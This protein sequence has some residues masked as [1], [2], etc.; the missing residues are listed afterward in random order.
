[1]LYINSPGGD[2]YSGLAVYDTIQA[3]K[4]P[5]HTFVMGLAAS[6]SY[7]LAISGEK[8]H[9]YALK[10]SRLMM[11]QPWQGGGGGQ[12]TDVM[13]QNVEIQGLKSDMIKIIS[14]H[15][16]QTED[17]VKL[18]AERDFWMNGE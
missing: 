15:T 10:H 4:A 6:M 18:D 8:K 17:K 13:I 5:V 16:G 1:S 7:I 11:H 9:R 2:C 14:K 12:A 3:I